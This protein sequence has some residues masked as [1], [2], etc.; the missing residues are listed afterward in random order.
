MKHPS[1]GP[2]QFERRGPT[3]P[4][5]P[6]RPKAWNHQDEL[7]AHY[8]K[9]IALLLPDGATKTGVLV[10]ADQFAVKVELPGSDGKGK[11]AL[12]F[13]KGS[14]FIAYGLIGA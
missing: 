3:A 4:R 7:K 13:L 10:A 14:G 11:S 2:V 12:T 6:N 5:S 8:G 1:R 9:G